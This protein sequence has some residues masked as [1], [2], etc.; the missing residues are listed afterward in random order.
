MTETAREIADGIIRYA[1]MD[2]GLQ[3]ISDGA[4]VAYEDYEA[5]I[6]AAE[7]R[8]IERAADWHEAKIAELKD[9]DPDPEL[10][11][12]V[13]NEVEAHEEAIAAILALSPAPETEKKRTQAFVLC[14]SDAREVWAA[15]GVLV[16]H[17]L[18]EPMRLYTGTVAYVLPALPN[19]PTA[20]E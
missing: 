3:P 4:W 19:P 16:D 11:I 10:P 8:G 15:A 14:E 18:L 5:A 13:W 7:R 20:K 2:G 17:K 12:S 6:L 1:E 9:G